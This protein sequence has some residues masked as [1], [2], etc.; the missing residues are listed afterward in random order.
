MKMLC[1][2]LKNSFGS[3]GWSSRRILNLS[4]TFMISSVGTILSVFLLPGIISFTKEEGALAQ[5]FILSPSVGSPWF[6]C[7]HAGFSV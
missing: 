1:S 7:L 2:G 4:G 3:C 6:R 5:K